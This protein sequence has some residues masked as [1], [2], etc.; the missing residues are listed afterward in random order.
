M[1]DKIPPRRMIPETFVQ[2]LYDY[3]D[4]QG[5]NAEQVLQHPWPVPQADGLGSFPVERWV[6]LLAR[7]AQHLN[8]P[9]LGLKLGQ[10]ITPRH[11]GVLGYVVQASENLAAVIRRLA[12]YQRLIYDVTP[13]VQR[14]RANHVELVWDKEHGMPGALVDETA[15]TCLVQFYRSITRTALNPQLVQ[16]LNPEPADVQP[17]VDY[18]GCP[19]LF[20]QAETIV[21]FGIEAL[22]IPLKTADPAMAALME[23]QANQLLQQL[24]LEDDY[25]IQVRQAIAR[26]LHDGEPDIKKVAT[27]LH[28]TPRTIQ[29]KLNA[30]STS[31][32]HELE[33][34]R[35][36]MA[37][38][39]LS[40]S[41][42][43]IAEIALLLG[44]SEHSAFSR[45]YKIWTGK[46]PLQRRE[47]R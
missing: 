40:D 23:R 13:M 32:S 10:T 30:L 4:A 2:L 16:F 11:L 6:E 28:S 5:V 25:V 47:Q 8:D 34:V 44:Y 19:V 15:I 45:R 37:E 43:S 20:D 22:V 31:F 3:L 33:I 46:T 9:L 42:L 29:R 17:Y 14:Y 21:R 7:A 26:L 27:L 38:T 41:R 39:Y 35:R 18:F 36:Q 1:M 12:Q 24:P